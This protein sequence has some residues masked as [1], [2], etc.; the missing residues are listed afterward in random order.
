MPTIDVSESDGKIVVKAELPG[1]DAKDIDID[2]TGDVLTLRGEKKAEKDIFNA[3]PDILVV[4]TGDAGNVC[5]SHH[6]AAKAK[7]RGIRLI[8]EKTP[9][10]VKIFNYLLS[11]RISVSGAFHLTC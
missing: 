5:I 2:I 8:S 4:G 3:N 7:T 11:N 10:A 9:K 1:L 6:V